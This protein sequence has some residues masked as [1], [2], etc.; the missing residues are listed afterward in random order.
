MAFVAPSSAYH[1]TPAET[2]TFLDGSA[3][4]QQQHHHQHQHQH[5]HYAVPSA[6]S[7]QNLPNPPFYPQVMT[8]IKPRLT[9]EQHDILETEFQRQNKPS[10]QVKKGFAENLNVS[11]DKVNNWFQ[12]RRAKSKQDAKKQQG[13]YNLF[14]QQN[15]PA[16]NFT[17]DSDTS[18]S[19]VSSDYYAMMPDDQMPNGITTAQPSHFQGQHNNHAS[20]FHSNVPASHQHNHAMLQPQQPNDMFDSPQDM[21]RRTL[22]QAQ[23]DVMAQQAHSSGHFEAMQHDFSGDA[24]LMNQVFGNSHPHDLKQQQ[25]AFAFPAPSGAPLS[26][27][28]SSIPSTISEQSMFPSSTAM[29]DHAALSTTSS[30]WGDSRSSSVSAPYTQDQPF[31]FV[32]AS[33]QQPAPTASSSQWQPGQSVPVDP[34]DLQRQFTE[35]QQRAQQQ[36]QQQQAHQQQYQHEQPLAFPADEAFIRRESH[37]GTMLAEQMSGFAIQTPQPQ[38]NSTFKTPAPPQANGASIAARRQRPRPANLGPAAMRSQSYS[39][40]A[41]PGSPGQPQLSQHLVAPGQLRRIRSSNVIHNGVAQGRVQKPIPGSAQRSPMART[42]TESAL[43]SPNVNATTRHSST[44]SG[45][46][47]PP[48]PM[49]P[50][51]VPRQEQPR[52]RWP[53]WQDQPGQFGRHAS[54]S[55]SD[56]ESG[57]ESSGQS[58]SSPPHTPMSQQQQQQMTA[59]GRVGST[60]ITENTPPQ[61]APAVQTSFPANAFLPVAQPHP[62]HAQQPPPQQAYVQPPAQHF[63]D[64][65]QFQWPPAYAPGPNMAMLPPEMHSGLPMQFTN[66]VPIVNAQGELTMAYPP[67]MQQMQ[68]M[69]QMPAQQQQMVHPAQYGF[70]AHSGASPPM[71]VTSQMPPQPTSELL[72]HEYSPPSDIKRAA[73]PRRTP[74]DSLPKTFTFANHTPEHF[75]KE[76]IK[77]EA[78]ASSTASSSPES[79]ALSS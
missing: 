25:H 15:P 3:P 29:Q 2:Q 28:D 69:Q 64:L 57:V 46:L 33:L 49:S 52:P 23:F 53:P 47:A 5:H 14:A 18:P 40:A 61:S 16:L 34:S 39:G 17:S 41:Q 21:N 70:M 51:D 20:S 44:S 48:T 78:K 43:N 79:A 50:S 35:A 37:S 56:A 24:E 36:Q 67:Q 54:I 4:K 55:E 12:N 66:G 1:D 22:T 32:T 77:K 26:S 71:H 75:E 74:G 68:F 8:D 9:K 72:V 38:R 7:L 27:N 59:Q 10:T 30:D 42:F 19:F 58:A 65:Q 76:K 45:N 13:A 6:S 31:P 60:V 63:V 11:L 73:T 62:M